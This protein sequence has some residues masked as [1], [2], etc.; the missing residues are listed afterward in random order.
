MVSALGLSCLE[1][2]PPGSA[3]VA[4]PNA[5][6]VAIDIER[7]NRMERLAPNSNAR[8][9]VAIFDP[10]E[11]SQ[12]DSSCIKTYQFV[13][14][15]AEFLQRATNKFLFGETTACDT[16]EF[17]T[18]FASLLPPSR[19]IILIAHSIN[20]DIASLQLMGFNIHQDPRLYLVD[21]FPMSGNVLH[22]ERGF[23]SLKRI[24][25]ETDLEFE[26]GDLHYAGND[27]HFTMRIALSLA[28][29]GYLQQCPS[30]GAEE[31]AI[32]DRVREQV[33]APIVRKPAVV[34]GISERGKTFMARMD[35]V[36]R[37]RASF[38]AE[39]EKIQEE[40]ST[41]AV[42]GPDWPF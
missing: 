30:P 36:S 33:M 41:C 10:L 8:L 7:G 23:G 29:R 37:A 26:P 19:P 39:N 20:S 31:M 12:H 27:A 28:H 17:M 24:L 16:C 15:D 22:T 5:L 34:K 21:T 40:V 2:P 13:S 18:H 1:T 38:K 9:G 25:A 11:N 6:M 14:G 3:A 35:E 42:Q 4:P 32:L